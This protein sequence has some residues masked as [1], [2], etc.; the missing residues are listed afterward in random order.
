MSHQVQLSPAISNS[1]I[2][3][4]PSSASA[5]HVTEA[6]AAAA[7]HRT[8]QAGQPPDCHTSAIRFERPFFTAR[9]CHGFPAD[10]GRGG[11]D[12]HGHARFPAF[13]PAAPGSIR[14]DAVPPVSGGPGAQPGDASAPHAAGAP[15]YPKQPGRGLPAR[16]LTAI[17]RRCTSNVLGICLPWTCAATGAGERRDL[18]RITRIM[19]L[20]DRG[21]PRARSPLD[22]CRAATERVVTRSGHA[23]VRPDSQPAGG[24][25]YLVAGGRAAR[26]LGLRCGCAVVAVRW[27]GRAA[28]LAAGR[29]GGGRR[30]C[31]DRSWPAAG[32]G[33]AQQ[34]GRVRAG[35]R[36]RPGAAGGNR[37]RSPCR[38]RPPGRR[39]TWCAAPEVVMTA[40]L[41]RPW[42]QR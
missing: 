13:L 20:R 28:V 8:G 29:G 19:P 33:R 1:P 23:L 10:T 2:G 30:A 3:T 12:P 36:A 6:P 25:V 18:T 16:L 42:P 34:R 11:T 39:P 9:P 31:R 35:H 21:G 41:R 4:L 32:P 15:R 37:L 17:D 26:G 14:R 24:P 22:E 5:G 40:L 7:A 38:W 27:G